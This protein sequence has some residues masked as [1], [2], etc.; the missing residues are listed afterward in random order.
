[1]ID[2]DYFKKINDTY[3]HSIGDIVLKELALIIKK[4]C[5]VFDVA[6]RI[7]GEEFCVLLFDCPKDQT[8]EI[9]SRINKAVQIYKF[10]IEED[11]FNKKIS[12]YFLLKI[13]II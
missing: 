9:A 6:A 11:K 5:I 10:L 1:M 7:G 8:F 12:V 4:N 3:G 2:I 13:D